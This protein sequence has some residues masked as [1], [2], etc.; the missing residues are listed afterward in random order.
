MRPSAFIFLDALPLTPNGKIDRSALPRPDPSRRELKGTYVAPRTAIEADLA[1]IWAEVLRHETVGVEDNFFELGGH[2]LMATQLI[3]RVRSSFAI[4]LPLRNLFESPT[5]AELASVIVRLQARVKKRLPATITR[6]VNDE[7]SAL[8]RKRVDQ[9]S[10]ED[11][12]ALL[13]KALAD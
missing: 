10:A 8:M 5:V 3:S 13:R 11:I 1:S 9:L 12:D 4:E 7:A 6:R 2:S